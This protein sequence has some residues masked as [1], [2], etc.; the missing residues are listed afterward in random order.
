QEDF[1]LRK[2]LL[3]HQLAEGE[4]FIA[5]SKLLLLGWTTDAAQKQGRLDL[6]LSA[7]PQSSL[8]V[9]ANLLGQA[10]GMFSSVPRADGAILSG[11]VNFVLDQMR[12]DNAW[13]LLPLL[14]A[15]TAKRIESS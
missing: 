11:R 6:E 7:I 14:R 12:K 4:R 10:P 2:A 8:D 13:G 15:S 3:Q 5:D 9:S 1:E